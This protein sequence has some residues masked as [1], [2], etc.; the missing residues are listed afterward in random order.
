MPHKKKLTDKIKK[1]FSMLANQLSPENLC[2]DGEYTQAQAKDK[3]KTLM[4]EWH[5]LEDQIGM[6]ITQETLD[7]WEEETLPKNM[8][9]ASLL[10]E[11]IDTMCQW[12]GESIA[13]KAGE[14][15]GHKVNYLGDDLFQIIET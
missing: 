1:Q 10:Q 13:E 9:S 15:L 7:L 12:S 11:L 6:K 4:I 2:G 14:I 8:D 5:K 3:F